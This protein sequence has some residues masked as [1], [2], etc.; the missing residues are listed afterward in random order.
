MKQDSPDL[1]SKLDRATEALEK[2]AAGKEP[3]QYLTLRQSRDIASATLSFIK[4]Q[5]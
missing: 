1:Q 4:E 5:Q 2:I 3:G